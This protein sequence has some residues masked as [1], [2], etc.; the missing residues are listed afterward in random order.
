MSACVNKV[1]LLGYLG[2]DPELR[3]TP[4]GRAVASFTVA[5]NESWKVEGGERE[6]R[7]NW[8]NVVAW[9]R[10][11]EICKDYL[12]KGSRVYLEDR[13][14]SRSYE[15]EEGKRA[16]LEVVANQVKMLDPA[17]AEAKDGSQDASKVKKARLDTEELP[18]DED[19]VPF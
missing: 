4:N 2:K 7:T 8:F 14:Q 1:I 13:L 11:A 5:I 19:G 3:F 17:K 16:L 18:I 10:L 9:N 6:Q 12:T 15:T